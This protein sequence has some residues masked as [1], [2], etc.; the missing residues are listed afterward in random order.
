MCPPHA[1]SCVA[2]PD[3]YWQVFA[4]FTHG[5]SGLLYRKSIPMGYTRPQVF[6]RCP[7]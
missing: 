4:V 3:A 7:V 5:Q 2:A 6:Y 1:R